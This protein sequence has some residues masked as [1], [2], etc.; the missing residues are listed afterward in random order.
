MRSI[1]TSLF[2][3]L[4]AACSDSDARQQYADVTAA[5]YSSQVPVFGDDI[6]MEWLYLT[7]TWLPPDVQEID[8]NEIAISVKTPIKH[9]HAKLIQEFEELKKRSYRWGSPEWLQMR[10]DIMASGGG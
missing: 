5:L 1:V 9:S 6:F 3:L 2:F 10:N 7:R 8:L 4:L